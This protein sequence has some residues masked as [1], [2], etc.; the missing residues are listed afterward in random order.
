MGQK[1]HPHGAR[2]GVIKDWDSRWYAD[3]KNFADYI[4]EDEKV[5]K[6]LKNK[7]YDAGISRIEIERREAN[8]LSLIHISFGV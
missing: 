3:K 8:K 1:V 7:L 5:R 4:V 6:F 2:V